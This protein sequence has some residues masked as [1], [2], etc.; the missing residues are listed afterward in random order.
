MK[1][2][3]LGILAIAAFSV[4]GCG[5][6]PMAALPSGDSGVADVQG[7]TDVLHDTEM[8]AVAWTASDSG[9]GR[10]GC[11]QAPIC[12]QS[13][14]GPCGCCG[15][16]AGE[17]LMVGTD[18]F[19]CSANMLCYQRVG[20]GGPF[21]TDRADA[22]TSDVADSA[23]SD[24]VNADAAFACGTQTCTAGQL[25]VYSVGGGAAP[26]LLRRHRL[27]ADRLGDGVVDALAPDEARLAPR[28][29][30]NVVAPTSSSAFLGCVNLPASCGA[31]PNC[32]CIPM[33][34]CPAGTTCLGVTADTLTCGGQ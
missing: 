15:C 25:C 28:L 21:G 24:G 31:V 9:P 4:A 16:I 22:G 26:P 1:R 8:E 12:G 18:V 7:S 19:R 23:P 11:D 29:L 17:V 14:N 30:G 5:T 20:D 3:A 2:T 10:C 33:T 13:C 27:L 34:A 32:N 6:S